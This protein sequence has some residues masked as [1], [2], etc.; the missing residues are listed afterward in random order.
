MLRGQWE[1]R[2]RACT[3]KQ[4]ANA[5][6]HAQI[7]LA[8]FKKSCYPKLKH[9]FFFSDTGLLPCILYPGLNRR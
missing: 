3:E 2:K 1:K 4:D 9:I 8:F 5:P 6:R 7:F